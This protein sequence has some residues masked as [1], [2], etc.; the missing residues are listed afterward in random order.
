MTHD[1][2]ASCTRISITPMPPGEMGQNRIKVTSNW[3]MILWQF[4]YGCRAQF[5][6]TF[7]TMPSFFPKNKKFYRLVLM[8]LKL[9]VMCGGNFLRGKDTA[10]IKRQQARLFLACSCSC[11]CN[12]NLHHNDLNLRDDSAAIRL[13]AICNGGFFNFSANYS[14][15]YFG[16]VSDLYFEGKLK[17]IYM[18]IY[19]IFSIFTLNFVLYIYIWNSIIII[20]K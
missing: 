17:Q 13:I 2:H 18:Y 10:W 1:E 4:W 20:T 12:C 11:K 9:S 8:T 19:I 14:I 5:H 15:K 7:M 3:M 16:Y 6:E